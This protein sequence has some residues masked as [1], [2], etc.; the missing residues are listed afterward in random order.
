[1][2]RFS[3]L[4]AALLGRAARLL[5]GRRREWAEA[6]LASGRLLVHVRAGGVGADG[7]ADAGRDRFRRGEDSPQGRGGGE[8]GA[9]A[10]VGGDRGPAR[11]PAGRAGGGPGAGRGDLYPAG[12]LRQQSI[13]LGFGEGSRQPKTGQDAPVAKPGDCLDLV[14][15]QGENQNAPC[16]PDR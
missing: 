16:P 2:D 11:R 8:R 9:A 14:L 4:L 10:G 6:A 1:M 13:K 3:R 7:V 12:R 5:P 15:G